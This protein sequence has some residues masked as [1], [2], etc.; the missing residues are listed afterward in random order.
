LLRVVDKPAP[1]RTLMGPQ[2]GEGLIVTQVIPHYQSAATGVIR[3][4][5]LLHKYH[6]EAE[7]GFISLEGLY[8]GRVPGRR[9]PARRP[10]LDDREAD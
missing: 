5:E 2:Y 4:R 7:A 10:R 8:R 6:P 1:A 9:T 3:Y